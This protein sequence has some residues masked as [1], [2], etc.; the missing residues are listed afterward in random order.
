MPYIGN[1]IRAADD[2]R[3][4]DDISSGFNGS[5]TSFALQVA[6]SAPVPFPKSPQQVLISVNGVIQEPDPSGSSGFNL[7]GT[8]I[9]FSSAPTNGHAFFGIIYATA[10]YLNAGGN[11]PAGS[12]GAPS[13]T[14]IG[15]ENSGL[16]R[17]SGGSVGF[18][19]DATEIAN[20]DSNG[21]TISSGNIII[22]D[23]IIHNGD[24]NTKIRFPAADTISAE[25]AG[26]EALRITSTGRLGINETNPG[27][28][29]V[30][31]G[32]IGVG[33]TTP[34]DAARQLNFN[35]NRGS[36]GDTLANINWQWNSKFVAQ[37]RGIAGSDTTNKD[38]A[39][40]AFF[41]SAANNLVERMRIDSSGR[42]GIGT[43][44]P[45]GKVHICEAATETGGDINVNADGLIVDNSGGNTGLTFKT[46]NSAASRICFGDPE[47]NNV[48]QI[49]Y[50]HSDNSLNV[51]V[52]ANER[53]RITSGGV[54]SI[55]ATSPVTSATNLAVENSGENNVYFVGN[56]STSGARLILQ[57]KNTT[58]N[59]FTGVLGADGGG[60]TT[61]AIKFYS[62]D[63]A[64]NE[65]YLTLETRPSGGIP[66][67]RMRIDSSGNVG[68]GASDPSAKLNVSGRSDLILT[69]SPAAHIG[70]SVYYFKIGQTGVSSSP[71]INAIGSQVAI[72]FQINGS[73]KMRID[74]NGDVAIG[75]TAAGG[76][77]LKVQL[78][79]D[80]SDAFVVKGGSGQGRTNIAID[81]GNTTSTA[82]TSFRLRDSSG[83]TVASL[84]FMNN[85]DDLIIGTQKQGGEVIFHTSTASNSLGSIYRAKFDQNGNFHL[86]GSSN[87]YSGKARFFSNNN[88]TATLSSI[89][90]SNSGTNR[91]I[92]FFHASATGRVGSIQ[93]NSSE[94]AFN[95]SSDYRLKENEVAISD[96]ITRLKK[97]KPYR[98]NFKIDPTRTV[99]GFFA[100]EVTPAVPE[101]ISGEK[102]AVDSNGDIEPQSIDQSK[103]VPLLTAALQEEIA[104][105]EALEARIAAL[106][107]A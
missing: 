26:S 103:L 56:T 92:D 61:A 43:S 30:V 79:D 64:N 85:A 94:T 105:R 63:N 22:P 45:D 2:Y 8:N 1:T 35:V 37:I 84:F 28:K 49:L 24:S 50:N 5:E 74:Q 12:L 6:G 97:L 78:T 104:K 59:S 7:V 99:D 4:I 86:G 101:A 11:F 10:D 42:L 69:G 44:G 39:H 76:N 107:A 67:E 51:H 34:N 31:G 21:I 54:V 18:V 100:H 27:Y 88:G 72:P 66:T 102:D 20:F 71:I 89:N 106:E 14:F 81:A 33:F 58:A 82:S 46:P 70:G 98:F 91:Q 32:D 23:S 95:T 19:S 68:I 87:S 80:N 65:G 41:T 40:L 15:D 25:T 73:E 13:I 17:K 93:T 48:G 57:N 38:D 16:Y 52:N 9:V 36:A 83:N 77:T 53:M 96:G 29:L 60:Q 55:G 47:D 3:L 62:A 75:T 90:L